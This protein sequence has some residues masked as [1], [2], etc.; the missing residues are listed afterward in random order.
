MLWLH[1]HDK[2]QFAS[3]RLLFQIPLSL[4]SFG[5]TPRILG[6]W[7]QIYF[8]ISACAIPHQHLPECFVR[9]AKGRHQ[10]CLTGLIEA[11]SYQ[12]P[13]PARALMIAGE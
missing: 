2:Q 10:S 5:I 6:F 8:Q 3:Y 1:D 13:W 9:G 12:G 4:G 11:V 7:A